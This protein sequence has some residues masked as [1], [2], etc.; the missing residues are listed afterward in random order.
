VQKAYQRWERPE[1]I[2]FPSLSCF[3]DGMVVSGKGLH[4]IDEAS[5]SAHEL[6][7]VGVAMVA[8]DGVM[9]GFPETLDCVDP[10]MIFWP[11]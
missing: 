2:P 9:Q 7:E 4:H 10:G 6:I 1:L 11:E 8:R 5:H 3:R